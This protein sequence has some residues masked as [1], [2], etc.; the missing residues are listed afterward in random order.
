M[1]SLEQTLRGCERILAGE[2]KDRPERVLYMIGAIDAPAGV[3]P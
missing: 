3:E 2:F 1:V